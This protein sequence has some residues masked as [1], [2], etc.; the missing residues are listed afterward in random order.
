M[1]RVQSNGIEIE[2]E[3]F[4]AS[5]AEAVLLIMGLGRQLVSWPETLCEMLVA[6][7][8]QVIRFDNRDV[9]LSS[10]FDEA[11]V[12]DFSAIIKD[13]KAGKQPQTP[14][15]LDDMADD[16][17]G[18]LSAL[19]IDSAHVVGASLGGMIAQTLAIRHPARVASLTSMMS[20]TGRQDLP[21][22]RPD[23]VA[24]LFTPLARE[25][26][27]RIDQMT[28]TAALL[29]GSAY[30]AER[31]LIR[32]RMKRAYERD[33]RATGTARHLAAI[34]TH[35]SRE[36]DLQKLQI[37]TLV[38]HGSDDPLIPVACGEITAEVI[39]NA[40]LEIIEGW[41][42]DLPTPLLPRLVELISAHASGSRTFAG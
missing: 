13:L 31:A 9:G 1:A 6:R 28:E 5:Q 42:H 8:Y 32:E 12:P 19:G 27:A 30:P 29:A 17:A 38:L 40:R 18:L 39:P 10:H 23:V 11:G 33:H 7:G 35:P 14:Y 25:Q 20:H 2:Y 41:G 15:S 21:S 34:L 22:G 26:E 4:G 16:A 3:R 36:P 24:R 37:P